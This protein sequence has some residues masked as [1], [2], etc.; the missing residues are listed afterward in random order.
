MTCREV[1]REVVWYPTG[2]G[3]APEAAEHIAGCERC[4]YLAQVFDEC[5]QVSI[6]SADR[7]R[8]IEA[9]ILRNLTPVQP[10]APP[11]VF[12]T[13]LALVFLAVVTVGFLLLGTNGWQALGIRQRVAVFTPLA[14]CAGALAMC[15]VRLMAPG[16]KHVAS[17]VLL[18]IGTLLILAVDFVAV[19]HPHQESTF[20]PIG[21]VCLETGL[22]C[23]VPAAV[24]FW[25][26]LR[27]GAIL[28]PGLTGATAGGLAGLVG[29]TVL[30][31]QCPN[32]NVYHILVWHLGT[33]LLSGVGGFA[34]GRLW[35]LRR[36][37]FRLP[38]EV[39]D[40]S[41]FNR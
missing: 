35:D 27:R 4:Q 7:L 3:L 22:A 21:L 28:S 2:S 40:G 20:V 19:F 12:L 26:F 16:S 25:L 29:L 5:H 6:P 24:L 34:L 11:S 38:G 17:P 9:A 13:C 37:G 33:A 8:S 31:V 23:A 18:S 10:L 36:N 32:V 15:L 41:G 14:A 39:M 1:E 30:Q